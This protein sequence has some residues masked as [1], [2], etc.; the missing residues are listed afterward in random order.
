MAKFKNEEGEEFEAF[1]ADEVEAAKNAAIETAKAAAIEEYKAAN[2][3]AAEGDGTA[4]TE[5]EQLKGLVMS[6]KQT[7][8]QQT[9]S[10]FAQQ[11]A[12]A[13]TAKQAEFKTKF[14]RLTGYP[15]TPEGLA[16]RAADAAK[17]IGVEAPAGVDVGGL[18]G[19]GGGRNVDPATAV[20]ATEAD[21]VV[22]KA[23][24]ITAEDVAKFGGEAKQ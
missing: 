24:G 21:K 22:Q 7:M 15:E 17:L 20:Q 1:T 8:E 16:E 4:P 3:P 10:G 5:V 9:V 13:D 11:F 18:A 6:L 19:T 12:G 14:D 2:P 23:L